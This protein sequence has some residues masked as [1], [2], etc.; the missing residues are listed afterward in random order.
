MASRRFVAQPTDLLGYCRWDGTSGRV[1][2]A[3]NHRDDF[4]AAPI[5]KG[6]CKDKASSV[7]DRSPKGRRPG[8]CLCLGDVVSLQPRLRLIDHSVEARRELG[9]GTG[10]LGATYVEAE[11]VGVI[12]I[13][14]SS[15][16]RSKRPNRM[17]QPV[18][19]RG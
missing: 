3:D 17:I 1:T 16:L 12:A 6:I 18:F 14:A 11:P 2:T 10:G 15:T 8:D 5:Q 9:D 19:E 4:Q 7:S 13:R